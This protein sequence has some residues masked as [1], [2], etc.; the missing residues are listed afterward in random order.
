MCDNIINNTVPHF[1]QISAMAIE[2]YPTKL[3]LR[4]F[5]QVPSA[6]DFLKDA[7]KYVR[8]ELVGGMALSRPFG[9][10][11]INVLSFTQLQLYWP[12]IRPEI[13]LLDYLF[14]SIINRN[15]VKESQAILLAVLLLDLQE[16]YRYHVKRAILH[17]IL[18]WASTDYWIRFCSEQCIIIFSISIK[19][20]NIKGHDCNWRN[21]HLISHE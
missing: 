3:I 6:N 21:C 9:I 5:L 11:G 8:Q 18:R 7:F 4:T 17:S 12:E 10:H 15:R 14:N 20:Q 16:D 19:V 2:T 1:P 13:I